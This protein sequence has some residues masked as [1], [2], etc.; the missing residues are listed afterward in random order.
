MCVYIY[1]YIYIYIFFFRFFSI[2]VYY[3]ILTI[4]PCVFF[5]T[6]GCWVLTIGSLVCTHSVP[7]LC[8]EQGT[9]TGLEQHLSPEGLI[10]QEGSKH[11]RNTLNTQEGTKAP[12]S[13]L[14]ESVIAVHAS[15]TIRATGLW[16]R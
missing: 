4:V 14:E 9:Q 8:W 12:R 6:D 7:T 10:V 5:I 16:G 13:S 11:H 1:I 3:K 2:I 15:V